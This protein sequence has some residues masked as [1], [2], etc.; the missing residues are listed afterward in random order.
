MTDIDIAGLIERIEALPYCTCNDEPYP[1]RGDHRETCPSQ[2]VDDIT[3]ALRALQ[4]ENERLRAETREWV[5]ESCMTCY[6][7]PPRPGLMSVI[8]PKC[9]GL[10]MPH[11]LYKR[12][13]VE[14]ERDSLRERVAG[15]ERV[16][17]RYRWLRKSVCNPAYPACSTQWGV[18]MCNNEQ[19]DAAIDAALKQTVWA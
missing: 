13:I 19:L 18:R 2:F 4:A 5:C 9:K 3:D 17:A 6:P 14:S 8:C 1:L 16:A 11:E 7:G 12:K 10:T 15:L